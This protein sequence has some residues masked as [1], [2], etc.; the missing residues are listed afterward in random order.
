M[1]ESPVSHLQPTTQIFPSI[2]LI[3]IISD[4]YE[5]LLVMKINSVS[6][7]YVQY[8][9][10]NIR[11]HFCRLT[12]ACK[13]ARY[14]S[15]VGCAVKLCGIITYNWP[16]AALCLIRAITAIIIVVTLPGFQNAFS[17]L[18]L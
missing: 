3:I 11:N 7:S 6:N 8:Q 9:L 14:T 4:L 5:R 16:A 18:A 1:N 17:R 12:R 13:E 10:I 2:T 15:I